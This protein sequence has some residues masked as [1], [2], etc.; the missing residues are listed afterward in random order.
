MP[1]CIDPSSPSAV[2][3]FCPSPIPSPI[4]ALLFLILTTL[5]T[6]Q[7]LH[8]HKPYCWVMV[9]AA[10]FQTATYTL[11]EVSVY[12]PTS[13]ALY[14]TW[15]VMI[16]VAPLWINAFV[17]M[18]LARMVWCFSPGKRLGGI[19][20]WRFGTVFVCLD[21]LWVVSLSRF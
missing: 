18:V 16:L 1:Q 8:H 20:A 15:F 6:Y 12:H 17:Y 11:R 7:T 5:H 19:R 21:V 10:L 9:T 4:F 2:W 3:P 14:S 13:V